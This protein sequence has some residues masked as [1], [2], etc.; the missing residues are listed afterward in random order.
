MSYLH[1]WEI[2]AGPVESDASVE[3]KF[4]MNSLTRFR[5]D[6]TDMTYEGDPL[7]V[8]SGDL[9]VVAGFKG[10]RPF[11]ACFVAV[12][13]QSKIVRSYSWVTSAICGLLLIIAAAFVIAK[14]ALPVLGLPIIGAAAL[15]IFH[16]LAWR[17]GQ[18]QVQL[19]AA[20]I[21]TAAKRRSG[22][23]PWG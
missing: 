9:L 11:K 10:V 22:T 21:G 8:R 7:G 16:G 3:H 5:I 6:G 4:L 15:A 13:G 18:R 1:E 2:L 14:T 19:R 20:E 17:D 12:P 23:G